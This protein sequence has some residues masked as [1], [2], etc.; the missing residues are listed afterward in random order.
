MQPSF[1]IRSEE[2]YK[3]AWKASNANSLA[4]FAG[5]GETVSE[6]LVLAGKI[7]DL[8]LKYLKVLKTIGEK[9]KLIEQLA[10][11]R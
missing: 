7:A 9:S 11:G 6:A 3:N 2:A 5:W 8:N 4:S 1:L 10:K